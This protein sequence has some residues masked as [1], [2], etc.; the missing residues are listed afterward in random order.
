MT[1]PFPAA[2]S[3]ARHIDAALDDL[4]TGPDIY[5]T[6]SWEPQFGLRHVAVI[7]ATRASDLPAGSYPADARAAASSPELRGRAGLSDL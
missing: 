1:W 4:A 7:A 5:S 2:D 3:D 6:S